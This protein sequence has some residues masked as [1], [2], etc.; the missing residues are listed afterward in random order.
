MSTI[1]IKISS[2]KCGKETSPWSKNILPALR[3][4]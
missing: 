4:A 2:I 1:S 3:F